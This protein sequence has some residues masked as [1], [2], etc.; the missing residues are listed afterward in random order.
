MLTRHGRYLNRLQREAMA[1]RE[2]VRALSALTDQDRD[3]LED[4]GWHEPSHAA[5]VRLNR[6]T[7]DELPVPKSRLGTWQW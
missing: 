1:D 4:R 5:Y 6:L 3:W 2:T 7:V